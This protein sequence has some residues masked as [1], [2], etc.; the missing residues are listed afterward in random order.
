MSEQSATAL[1]VKGLF[2]TVLKPMFSKNQ[3]KK[4]R[5]I[6]QHDC[7]LGLMTPVSGAWISE[8]PGVMSYGDHVYAGRPREVFIPMLY[9]GGDLE[10]WIVDS[11]SG[12]AVIKGFSRVKTQVGKRGAVM[13][14]EMHVGRI[15]DKRNFGRIDLMASQFSECYS[16]GGVDYGSPPLWSILPSFVS[17]LTHPAEGRLITSYDRWK[18]FS[19]QQRI[20]GPLLSYGV[21]VF[22]VAFT[23]YVG[24]CPRS[25]LAGISY[26]LT[27]YGGFQHFV[28]RRS[29]FNRAPDYLCSLYRGTYV[30]D[31]PPLLQDNPPWFWFPALEDEFMCQRD[32]FRTGYVNQL[33][34]LA[35]AIERDPRFT[36]DISAQEA[37]SVYEDVVNTLVD[38]LDIE[39]DAYW[40]LQNIL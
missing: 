10:R 27:K 20:M 16:K 15:Y 34:L 2:L 40:L 26:H 13:L 8:S 14:I 7:F 3:I 21:A 4:L 25:V 19:G 17:S 9:S 33:C 5:K 36:P 32:D 37:I 31:D 30:S 24:F 18:Y 39:V 29:N 12:V 1:G 11:L 35:S 22:K 6:P 38:G 23:R 28:G